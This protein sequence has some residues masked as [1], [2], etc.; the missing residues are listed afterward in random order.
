M[1]A[2]PQITTRDEQPYAAIRAT[3]TMADLGQL[4]ARFGEVFAW[5]GARGVAPAGAPF[6]KYN[7]IDMERE[8]EVEA[9]VPLA[10]PVVGDDQ[11][12]SGVLPAGQYVTLT[13][14]GPPSELIDANRQL[15][16]WA[17]E[18]DLTWDVSADDHG[19][20][21]VS[22]LE[23]YLTDPDVE[24]DMSKWETELAFR[25]AD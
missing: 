8:L 11:M 21:W 25:L 9:G 3:V 14:V 15:L 2:A 17:A 24:P 1:S 18:Q 20:R 7:V 6:F 16:E 23:I 13:H 12:V 5:L 10:A 4:A 19:E 22:R